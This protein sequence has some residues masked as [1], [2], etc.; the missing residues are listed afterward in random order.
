M[1]QEVTLKKSLNWVQGSAITIGSVIGAG[2]LILPA[3]TAAMAGPGA[4]V[5]WIAMGILSLPMIIVI[6]AMSASRPNAGGITAYADGICPACGELTSLLFL[7]AL[8]FGMPVTALVGASYFG[9]LWGWGSGGIHLC[10]AAMILAAVLFNCLGVRVSGTVQLIFVSV[11][12]AILL[13]AVGSGIPYMRVSSFVPLFPHG[14]LPVIQAVAVIFFAFTGWE[15]IGN[16]AEEFRDPHRDIPVSLGIS[17]VAVNGVYISLVAVIIGTAVYLADDPI[18]SVIRLASFGAGT[19][20]A[21]L[22]AVLGAIACY[23]PVHT[24]I[25]GFARVMY[26]QA[27]EGK[28]PAVFGKLHP[29]FRTPVHALLSFLP[30]CFLTLLL[31][32][33][34]QWDIKNLISIPA[35]NFLLVY[36]IGMVGA[37]RLL[38]GRWMKRTAWFSAAVTGAL[39]LVMG[40]YILYP[41]MILCLFAIKKRWTKKTN[42]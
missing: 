9:S 40:W 15:I 39:F 37:G 13:F 7:G 41:V 35:T 30:V 29:H 42:R 10:A 27:R 18:D 38:K 11:I 33:L 19:E 6:S 24:F 20:A 26:A 21:V 5:S 2:I 4:L 34:F 14:F 36:T 8:P 25:A 28:L 12:L 3:L 22:I 31:D 17:A 23:C 16:L 32:E 1:E